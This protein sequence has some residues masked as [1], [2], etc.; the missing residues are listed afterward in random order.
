MPPSRLSPFTI[1]HGSDNGSAS[2]YIF[3]WV[4]STPRL[5][6]KYAD[7]FA[8]NQQI[9]RVQHTTAKTIDVFM[10]EG[11]LES[12][13]RLALDDMLLRP[14]EPIILMMMSNGGV[15]VYT[16]LLKILKKDF[17]RYESLKFVGTIFDSAPAYLTHDSMARAPTEGIKSTTLRSIAYWMWRI[18]LV[19]FLHVFVFGLDAPKR[20]WD[21]LIND[22]L[23]CPSL[24]IYSMH[25]LLTDSQ[26][27]DELVEAR[28]R[29]HTQKIFT[30]KIFNTEEK[31]PH[32]M[33]FLKHPS[34][35]ERSVQDFIKYAL[36]N[37]K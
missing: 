11:G 8:N 27:I 15:L 7:L 13:A 5:L 20:F 21:I 4:G 10:N 36:S 9:V 12:L 34:R 6:S 33:H 32:V 23:P 14:N 29:V 1:R 18:F 31:S 19:P 2:V 30:L 35:Y 26:R 16:Q 25:D 28:Q 22:S 17:R 37:A 24:Y 3:G